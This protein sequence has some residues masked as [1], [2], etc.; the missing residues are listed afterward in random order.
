MK[1]ITKIILFY[2]FL[3][4]V[5]IAYFVIYHSPVRLE[6]GVYMN[7]PEPVP[8]FELTDNQGNLFSETQLKGHWTL[9]FF[10][11]SR[12]KMV[13]PLTMSMLNQT[14]E[15]LPPAQRPQVIFISV[16]PEYDS[17]QELNQFVH[18][19]NEH[20]IA[21]RGPISVINSLQKQLHITVS[22]SPMSHGTEILLINPEARV[23]AYFY[24]PITTK[25][26]LVD[27]MR[28]ID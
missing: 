9:I 15:Q 16:D 1:K 25:D 5:L 6:H 21:L 7:Q 11:F 17:V 12:C 22:A 27:L 14:Y 3:I 13:C 8:K 10:G 19:F 18:Q 20:F 28:L 4:T 2:L 26:L 24:Y 23:Q